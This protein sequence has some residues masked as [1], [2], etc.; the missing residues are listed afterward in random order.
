MLI[1]GASNLKLKV[2]LI[3]LVWIFCYKHADFRLSVNSVLFS[4]SDE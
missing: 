3:P 2:L 1:E 4:Y